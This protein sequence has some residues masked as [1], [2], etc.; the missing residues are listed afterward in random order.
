MEKS[1]SK[2]RLPFWA[3]LLV[4]L[5]I[6]LGVLLST[7]DA[8]PPVASEGSFTDIAEVKFSELGIV[9]LYSPTHNSYVYDELQLTGSLSPKSLSEQVVWRIWNDAEELWGV[10][11]ST[12]QEEW[13]FRQF[14][15]TILLQKDGEPLPDGSYTIALYPKHLTEGTEDYVELSFTIGD[16]PTEPLD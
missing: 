12:Y 5:F 9:S 11:D 13:K 15:E 10:V 16:A 8:Q 4:F 14:D 3:T 6:I 2:K 7:K 1:S